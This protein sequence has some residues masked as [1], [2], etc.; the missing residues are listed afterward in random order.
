MVEKGSPAEPGCG[1][2]CL[3][4]EREYPG[5]VDHAFRVGR[6]QEI[7]LMYVPA[8]FAQTDPAKLFD[9]IEQNSFGLLMSQLAGEPFATHLPLLLDREASLHGTLIGHVA[10]ANPHW[11]TT[12][13][14]VLAVFSG[15]HSYISPSWYQA[16]NVVPTWNYLA[17]HAYGKL[18]IVEDHAA[19]VKIVQDFVAFYEKSMPRPWT[20]SPD[21]SFVDKMVRSVVC[22]RIELSRLEGKWK[23]NQNHPRE[24][25]E[26]VID[27]LKHRSDENSQAI[28]ALMAET[29]HGR[30]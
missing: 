22:F 13:G 5:E 9:F 19:S 18:Q 17:V 28:A 29:L 4:L 20:V 14:N 27:A 7:T 15:P 1:W 2:I 30:S 6:F 23:L 16:E 21:D 3:A 25:R 26:K 12:D 8:H 10:R 11:Q 24:R